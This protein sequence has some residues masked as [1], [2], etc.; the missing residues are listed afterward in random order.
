MFINCTNHK[1]EDWNDKQRAEALVWGEIIDFQ[2]PN[3]YPELDES[4]VEKLANELVL[5]IMKKQPEIVLCQG[6]FTLTYAIIIKLK[7]MG[8][9]VI[10]ACSERK[11]NENVLP[12]GTIKKVSYYEFV[13]FR[14]Y[15]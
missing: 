10:A 15:I 13:R 8:V 5:E 12:N 1:V 14:E 9:K 4:E 3:V 7:R 6:E 2:F 11:I